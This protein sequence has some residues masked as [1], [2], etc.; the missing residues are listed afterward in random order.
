MQQYSVLMAVYHKE[1]PA[2]FRLAVSSM[3][4]QTI[5]PKEIV[6]VCDG[7]LPQGLE[8]VLR[9]FGR[10][11]RVIRLA[12][13]QGL[14]P[15][16]DIGLRSCRQELVARMDAD[17][18]AVPERMEILLAEMERFPNASVI[19]GQIAEFSEDPGRITGYRDVPTCP[20]NIRA[21]FKRRNPMNHM[22]VLLRK[23]SVLAVGSYQN[24]P[25][26]EDYH[27]WA[28]LLAA[29]Y[30]L[31]NVPAVCC[32]VRA[33]CGL[34][35]RRGGLGYFRDTCRLEWALWQLGLISVPRL[36]KNLAVRFAGTVLVSKRLRRRLYARYNRTRTL[37]EKGETDGIQV[38][39]VSENAS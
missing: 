10:R 16:L 23:S 20:E 39:R 14:G 28:R 8:Q 21:F 24:M 19:G 34:Y 4:R 9:E 2:Q 35:E 25:N 22:T 38:S 36:C 1:Q 15:A 6:V 17:D 37:P 11:L 30:E 5:P 27:L 7:P 13:H 3:L 12:S 32:L 29:G 26:F 31:R 33:N 18:I